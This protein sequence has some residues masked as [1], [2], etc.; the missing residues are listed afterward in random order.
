MTKLLQAFLT[1]VFFTFILDFQLFLGIKLNY[2]DRYEIDE[3]YNILFADHQ[4]LLYLI[5]LVIIIGYVTTYLKTPKIALAVLGTFSAITLLVF[6]PSIGEAVGA[7]VLQKENA[8]F[9]DGR[10]I[11]R[12][13]LFYEGRHKITIFD[14]EL[15]RLITLD[16]KDLQP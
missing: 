2:I 9:H 15:Q 11:Y 13:T 16:K 10:Y 1:G 4:N 5:P 3:Y 7:S 12:G 6:I 14:D 8:R